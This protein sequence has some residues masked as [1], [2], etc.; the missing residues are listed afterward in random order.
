MRSLGDDLRAAHAARDDEMRRL[1]KAGTTRRGLSDD[2]YRLVAESYLVLVV[3]GE[4][5]VTALAV[6]QDVDKST[7]SR[8]IDGA[9]TRGF[10]VSKV[11]A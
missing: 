4:P 5:P 7:A 11:T 2:F 10:L 8:W 9:R 3:K 1:R 6:R